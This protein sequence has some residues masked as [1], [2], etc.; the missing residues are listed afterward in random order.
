M[1]S[2]SNARR[3]ATTIGVLV[4]GAAMADTADRSPASLPG[5]QATQ[6]FVTQ[7]LRSQYT[8]AVAA[9]YRMPSPNGSPGYT[10]ENAV[11]NFSTLL[12]ELVFDWP[13]AGFLTQGAGGARPDFCKVYTRDG[14]PETA[15]DDRSNVLLTTQRI[16]FPATTFTRKQTPADTLLGWLRST[17]SDR[18]ASAGPGANGS[19]VSISTYFKNKRVTQVVENQSPESVLYLALP[20][21]DERVL[22]SLSDQLRAQGQAERGGRIGARSDLAAD[23]RSEQD[24]VT[25]N[26]LFGDAAR[27][28]VKLVQPSKIELAWDMAPPAG[29]ALEWADLP[30]VVVQ[31]GALTAGFRFATPRPASTPK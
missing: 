26:R 15:V 13:A 22:A 17:I 4:C 2:A 23:M 7:H 20:D 14:V 6:S 5:P 31:R 25:F 29:Q 24:R 19:D 8:D 28:L 30:V 21:L 12:P 3:L 27:Y 16:A 1:M 9:S 10:L 18:P 11:C